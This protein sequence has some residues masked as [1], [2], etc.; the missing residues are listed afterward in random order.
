M[1]YQLL[2]SLTCE[3]GGIE[4]WFRKQLPR[5]LRGI[6]FQHAENQV[7]KEGTAL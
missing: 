4:T 3:H 6:K 2:F 5:V 1:R 7:D